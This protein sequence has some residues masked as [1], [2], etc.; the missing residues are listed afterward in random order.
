MQNF[1]PAFAANNPNATTLTDNL[2]DIVAQWGGL[3]SP[4]EVASKTP[5]GCPTTTRSSSVAM[6]ASPCLTAL[7]ARLPPWASTLELT[8]SGAI[9][10]DVNTAAARENT[11]ANAAAALDSRCSSSRGSMGP[12]GSKRDIF[13]RQIGILR[14]V[15]RVLGLGLQGLR[16]HQ[17]VEDRRWIEFAFLGEKRTPKECQNPTAADNRGKMISSS[18]SGRGPSMRR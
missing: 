15:S 17:R 9:K 14:L 1:A 5:E 4:N 16:C 11:V 10:G 18:G 6:R 13:S 8:A 2:L 3:K 7:Q 12:P